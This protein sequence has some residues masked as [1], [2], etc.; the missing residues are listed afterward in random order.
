MEIIIKAT[1]KITTMDGVQVRVWDGVTEDG[2][3][4]T[5][6]VHRIA[7]PIETPECGLDREL[8]M[9]MPPGR[10]VDLRMVLP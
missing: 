10:A 8:Q 2:I 3:K 7:I 1:D 5:V 6:F 4:C 9:K